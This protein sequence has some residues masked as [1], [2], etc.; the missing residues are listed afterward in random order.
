MEG[1]WASNNLIENSKLRLERL[2]Y[3][4]EVESEEG[5][6]LTLDLPA[7]TITKSNGEVITFDIDSF[8][9]HCLVEGL[10]DIDMTLQDS[11]AVRAYEE[12]RHEEA[13]WLFGTVK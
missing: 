1:A 6:C 10:D 4:K 9:K 2:G 7:Q 8:R 5:Y 12:R 13:P 11:D 3:F